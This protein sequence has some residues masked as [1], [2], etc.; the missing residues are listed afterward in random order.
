MRIAVPTT[1][2]WRSPSKTLSR[3]W[4]AFGASPF[5]A[6]TPTMRHRALSPRRPSFGEPTGGGSG[7][8]EP[9]NL[10]LV[11]GL[12]G[13][14]DCLTPFRPCG[15]WARH[16]RRASVDFA[17]TRG[18]HRFYQ[19]LLVSRRHVQ[20]IQGEFLPMSVDL[21]R[22]TTSV[23]TTDRPPTDIIAPTWFLCA[24][25]RSRFNEPLNRRSGGTPLYRHP[26]HLP[27]GEHQVIDRK[28]LYPFLN[29]G[30]STSGTSY[31]KV[32][33]GTPCTSWPPWEQ[34]SP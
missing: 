5:A 26:R 12:R 18:R 20:A 2:T 24:D 17:V 32:I 7:R 1:P 33:H 22:K 14:L 16:E 23:A 3:R 25:K 30:P 4:A 11:T 10:L 28:H 29:A 8:M 6:G 19:P 13:R 9:R 27:D 15:G 34:A 31:S 21:L